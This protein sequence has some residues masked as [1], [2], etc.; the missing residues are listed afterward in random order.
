MGALHA[1][2]ISLY[3]EARQENDIVVSSIFV[4][5]TQFNNLEDLEKYLERL[6]MISKNWKIKTGRCRLHPKS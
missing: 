5:P 4:N 3:E 2:H 6:K 1:G